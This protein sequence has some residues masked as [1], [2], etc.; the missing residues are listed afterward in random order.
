MGVAV[1]VGGREMAERRC[2]YLPWVHLPLVETG[3]TVVT[4]EGQCT[5]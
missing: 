3:E 2:V 5:S 4:F 1:K